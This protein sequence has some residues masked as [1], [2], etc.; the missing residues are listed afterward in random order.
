MQAQQQQQQQAIPQQQQQRQMGMP[1]TIRG[2]QDSQR[3][4]FMR[5]NNRGR[6][7]RRP[8]GGPGSYQGMRF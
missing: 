8:P 6:R 3:G 5:G 7:M 1:I 4:M 2:V